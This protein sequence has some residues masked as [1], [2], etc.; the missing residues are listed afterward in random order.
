MSKWVGARGGSTAATIKVR[1]SMAHRCVFH[2][3]THSYILSEIRGALFGVGEGVGP[4][5]VRIILG[6]GSGGAVG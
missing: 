2:T 5:Q 1:E 4:H 6:G 3:C